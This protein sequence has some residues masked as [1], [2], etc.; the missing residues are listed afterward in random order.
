MADT[1]T[2]DIGSD[3]VAFYNTLTNFGKTVILCWIFG[4]VGIPGNER[5]YCVSMMST[6]GAGK[7]SR[8][9]ITSNVPPAFWVVPETC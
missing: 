1:L 8:V 3:R 7:S 4:Y 9:Q 5:A 2:G 6:A